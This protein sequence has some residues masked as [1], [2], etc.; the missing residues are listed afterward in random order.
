MSEL[1]TADELKLATGGVFTH[2]PQTICGLQFDSRAVIAGDLFLA[3]QGVRDG[4]D[5]V[6]QAISQGAVGAVTQRP[7]AGVPCLIVKNVQTALEQMAVYARNRAKGGLRGA[8]TGSVGKTSVT[9]MVRHVLMHKGNGHA[10]IKSFNNHIGV[11]L[12]LAR[13]PRDTTR[14]V[15]ELGMN[16][17]GEIGPLA[18]MV[19]PKACVI[20]T[21]GAVHTEN[22]PD[23]EY[24]VAKAKAEIFQ[25]L[26]PGDLAIMNADN[27]WFDTLSGWAQDLGLHVASFGETGT[28]D[29]RLGSFTTERDEAHVSASF[30]GQALSFSWPQ[31]GKHQAVNALSAL[32]LLE[33]LGVDVATS[34][35]ALASFAALDGRGRI[36]N[37]P[38]LRGDMTLIDESYNA[39][40]VSMRA[41]IESFGSREIGKGQRKILVLTDML[42]LG[43]DED[44]AH[45]RLSHI[46]EAQNIDKVYCAGPLMRHLMDAL[47]SG[48]RGG[49]TQKAEDLL[50]VLREDLQGGDVIMIKGSNGSGAHRIARSL[51][52]D[53]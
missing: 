15:F 40:P 9:Q 36:I 49:Y 42:E 4:H 27:V 38:T 16:H 35:S 32:L 23:G 43:P 28:L 25:G 12:T 18:R 26:R 8:V 53:S 2:D 39:N 50:A 45:A 21:V 47:S 24:G 44:L 52:H 29:A 41:T 13:M 37:L 6:A 1:W 31:T 3:L 33:A 30:H 17:A 48:L 19:A 14:A 10:A 20:T 51:I 7:I 11:P 5:F 34:V 46:I 22:F